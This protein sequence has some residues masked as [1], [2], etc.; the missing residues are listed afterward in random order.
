MKKLSLLILILLIAQLANAQ[1]PFQ[2][3]FGGTNTSWGNSIQ[4]TN[5]NGYISV[6]VTD[7][8]GVGAFDVFAI[9]TDSSGNPI[10]KKAIGETSSDFANDVQQTSDSG[11]IV[12]GYSISSF[13][14]GFAGENI[15]L[16]KLN[17]N[18]SILWS[19]IIGGV[20]NE[21][22]NSVRQ[23]SDGG[24]IIAGT[25]NS[26]GAGGNDFYL[27]KTDG[28]G[29]ISWTK[30][31]GGALDDVANSVKQT[32]DGGYIVAG[33][34]NSFGAGDIDYYLIKT[35]ALGT[36]TWSKTFGGGGSDWLYSVVQASDDGYV[37]GGYSISFLGAGEADAVVIKTDI[38]GSI[39]WSKT[40]GE[41]Y[42]DVAS[43]I[44]RTNDNGYALAGGQSSFPFSMVDKGLLF[45]IDSVGNFIWANAFINSNEVQRGI[46]KTTDGG[47]A[48][49]GEWLPVSGID[50][51][52]IKTNANGT[53]GCNELSTTLISTNIF[54]QISNPAT[55]SSNGGAAL[56]VT[57]LSSNGGI[58]T[59]PCSCSSYFTL[60]ADI[61]PHNWIAVNQATGQQPIT[62]S[63]NWGDGSAN[64][65]GSTPSHTYNTAGYY[66][67]CLSI[68]DFAGCTS[69]YCDSSTYLYKSNSNGTMVNVNVILP[70]GIN[71]PEPNEN[72]ISFF[73]N[74]T[75]G[76]FIIFFPE[77]FRKGKIEIYNVMGEKIYI[78]VVDGESKKEI[79]FK[80]ISAGIYFVKVFDVE[81]SF[82]KKLIVE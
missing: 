47:Y 52:L 71:I 50:L 42:G 11:F 73:P 77:N 37:M 72:T 17:S 34:T 43:S 23:T 68:T 51:I 75:S 62:Y 20:G 60:Y 14:G 46:C 18:G 29:N 41:Q 67:I 63:W 79:N 16:I 48:L 57:S 30:T 69:I 59:N 61:I 13:S 81:K 19:K 6:G 22:A 53:V 76:V 49:T 66:N 58:V 82:C 64:S 2:K 74:P 70:T 78:D 27:V 56:T 36:L 7:A 38:T 15:Y 21:R 8:F 31:F 39:L 32:S 40:Y 28:N 24:F 26:W 35:D 45:K 55:L 80:N 12:C 44:V 25:T 33:E 3:S 4:Q 10:W 65:S 5:D 9:K 54:P 1:I